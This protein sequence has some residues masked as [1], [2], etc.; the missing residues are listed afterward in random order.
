MLSQGHTSSSVSLLSHPSTHGY[1]KTAGLNHVIRHEAGHVLLY[2]L[3]DRPLAG[4]VVT[5]KAGLTK[6]IQT[7]DTQEQII[8][9]ILVAL[10][11]MKMGNDQEA[12]FELEDHIDNPAH[13]HAATDSR[14]VADAMQVFE[15][16]QRQSLFLQCRTILSRVR[17][18]FR[19]VYAEI[20]NRLA[21]P[22]HQLF[23]AELN[24]LF[25][26]W[27]LEYGFDKR[28]KSDYV[29]RMFHRLT[30]Q[31]LPKK[32][33]WLD[34]DNQVLLEWQYRPM[35]LKDIVRL[36]FQEESRHLAPDQQKAN[37]ASLAALE[38]LPED[39]L[40]ARL[41]RLAKGGTI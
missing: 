5:D 30:S 26:Q 1:S 7:D 33:Q 24:Q 27:D 28:P 22:P 32:G 8:P 20:C 6:I 19:K 16:S 12:I 38:K 9:H 31:P 40:V 15:Q 29:M 11:G 13:F 3:L 39:V 18:H 35:S 36:I 25:R 4:C 14:I 10:A 17:T 2:W 21:T 23:F 34:W 37:A 41:A